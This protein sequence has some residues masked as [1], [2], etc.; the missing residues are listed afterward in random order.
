MAKRI[1]TIKVSERA[2]NFSKKFDLKDNLEI[3]KNNMI[4]L[5]IRKPGDRKYKKS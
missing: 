4:I 5:E 3:I 1:Y 2:P